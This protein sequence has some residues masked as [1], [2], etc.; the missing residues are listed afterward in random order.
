[1][2][3]ELVALCRS[4]AQVAPRTGVDGYGEPL[5]GADVARRARV[6]GR[7]RTVTNAQGQQVVSTHQVYFADAGLVGAHDRITL[8]TGDVNSTET[9]ARQPAI[10][11]V[12]MTPDDLG[13]RHLTVYLV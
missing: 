12:G 5:F 1:M 4:T 3:P 11:A 7:V 6:T 8:S 9:G 13:R 10:L 2:L